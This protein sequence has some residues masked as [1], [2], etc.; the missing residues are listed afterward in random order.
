MS[1]EQL[2]QEIKQIQRSDPNAKQAWWD[3]CDR[4]GEGIKD[5]NR[6]DISFLR[7]YLS[8]VGHGGGGGAPAGGR[9]PPRGGGGASR[10]GPPPSGGMGMGM[11]PPW[12]FGGGGAQFAAAMGWGAAP[13]AAPMAGAGGGM[14]LVEFVKAGQ[15]HSAHWKSAWQSYCVLFG[16]GKYD[17]TKYDDAFLVSFI[18]YA[19]QVITA[20]L[21]AQADERGVSL[22]HALQTQNQRGAKRAAPTSNAPPQQRAPK[23]AN[24]GGY[25][26]GGD[27]D[28]A[29]A[30]LVNQIKEMQRSNPD[31][32]QAWWTYCDEQLGGVKDPRRHGAE[33]LQ[34]FIDT[35][36]S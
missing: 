20:D 18:D 28:P 26:A 15:R 21:T 3:Y 9:G 23:R 36:G 34:A 19:G 35:M 8:Q 32:K 29:K 13:T 17:P 33:V 25:D 31:A 10:G 5:P 24:V 14:P 22:E 27:D 12:S 1:K 30:D 7:K 16:N 6:H 4:A 2:V 11:T